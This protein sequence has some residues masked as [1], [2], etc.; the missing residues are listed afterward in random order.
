MSSLSTRLQASQPWIQYGIFLQAL[1]ATLGSLYFST[2]GDIAA[3]LMSGNLF[4]T[5]LGLVPCMLC[6]FARI[7]M[8]P[9]VPIS[10]VGMIKN[11]RRFTD[12]ILPLAIP[13]LLLEIYHYSLQMLP[14]KSSFG[15][16]MDNPCNALQVAYF[17]F[18]TIPFLCL[19][20]FAVILTLSLLNTWANRKGDTFQS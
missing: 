17:G 18:I 9:I 15:C 10:V 8:Y 12:Y 7:L 13:G 6:W 2:Y 11:D 16:T 1:V 5:S 20:A 14:I 3:N 19:V 4:D